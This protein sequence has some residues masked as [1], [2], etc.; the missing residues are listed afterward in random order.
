MAVRAD[1]SKVFRPIVEIVTVDMVD[2]DRHGSV[3]P[4]LTRGTIL[5]HALVFEAVFYH[6][7]T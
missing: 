4:A 5:E 1:E 7:S 6:C 3:D 2:L